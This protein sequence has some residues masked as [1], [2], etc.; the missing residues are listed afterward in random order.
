MSEAIT[1]PTTEQRKLSIKPD[2]IYET[3][4]LST[5]INLAP[6]ALNYSDVNQ[7]ILEKLKKQVEGKCIGDGFIK[8]ESVEIISRSPG[9]MFNN[10]FTGSIAYEIKYSAEVCNPKEGQIIEVVVEDNNNE[11]NTVCY[12]VDEDTSPIEIYLFKQHYLENTVYAGLKKGDKILV[13]ILDTQ[14]E[15][16][17]RK[18]LATAEFLS[19][20]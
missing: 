1:T 2:N 9:M 20:V 8:D 18:I 17:Q 15:F 11:T 7:I 14:I 4:Q 16:G 19:L 3:R 6:R 12:F 10:D 5:Q 13:K